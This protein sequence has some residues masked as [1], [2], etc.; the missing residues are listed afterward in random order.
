MTDPKVN[1]RFA[2]NL[3]KV[4]AERGLNVRWLMVALDENA[5]RIYPA[6]RGETNLSLELATRI[7]KALDV[8]LDELVELRQVV[9]PRKVAKPRT[10]LS[11][12]LEKSA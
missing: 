5:N 10:R 2:R 8:S 7:A 9:T 1:A 4:L 3:A 12:I 11:R 6:C